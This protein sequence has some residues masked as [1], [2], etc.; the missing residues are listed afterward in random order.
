MTCTPTTRLSLA[1]RCWLLL[2]FVLLAVGCGQSEQITRYS[3]PKEAPTPTAERDDAGP[4]E[5]QTQPASAWFFKLTGPADAVATI[6][7][8]FRALVESSSIAGG[9]PTWTLPDGWSRQPGNSFRF[10]TLTTDKTDPPL[11]VSVSRLTYPGGRDS[12]LR[13]NI[14]RWRGQVGLPASNDADWWAKAEAAGE[15]EAV[16]GEDQ[17]TTLVDLTG[18]NED[19]PE[20]RTLA[21]ILLPAGASTPAA[22]A[23]RTM[24]PPTGA[25]NQSRPLNYEAPD[26]WEPGEKGPMRVAA[27]EVKDG[28]QKVEITVIPAGG[29]VLSNVNLWRGQ[30][31]LGEWSEEELNQE[32]RELTVDGRPAT[33]VEL[34]G[35]QESIRG[36]ILPGEPQSWF[37]K[38]KGDADLA[39]RE[40]E[41]FKA[42]VESVTFP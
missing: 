11:E 15:V 16:G 1:A 2:S 34:T 10:A 35:E 32:A 21:A 12:Y 33:F 39:E 6:K 27:F 38:L 19:F 9:E 28:E 41:R 18:T 30:V 14:N 23:S 36:A 7:D 40:T 37:F 29:D 8:D 13:D 17:D 5:T 22:P 3:V 4:F 25:A 42:F 26:E 20:A 24:A 31:G